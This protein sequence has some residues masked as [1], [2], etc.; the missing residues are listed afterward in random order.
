MPVY[1]P[2]DVARGIKAYRRGGTILYTV[3]GEPDEVMELIDE[4]KGRG[5]DE[6]VALVS[7]RSDDAQDDEPPADIEVIPKPEQ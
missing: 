4:L 5:V 3:R 6:I 1:S 7:H 2:L